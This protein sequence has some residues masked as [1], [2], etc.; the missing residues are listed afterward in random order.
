LAGKI[1]AHGGNVIQAIPNLKDA[2]SAARN[3]AIE[4]ES[5]LFITGSLYLIG[6]VLEELQQDDEED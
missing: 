6:A 1:T 4:S 5:A 3:Y 2:L